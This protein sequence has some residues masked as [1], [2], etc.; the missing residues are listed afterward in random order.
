MYSGS[1]TD[2]ANQDYFNYVIIN[3]IKKHKV[4]LDVKYMYMCDRNCLVGN[5]KVMILL[6]KII[7]KYCP[8]ID[9]R[10]EAIVLRG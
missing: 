3:Y 10:Q 5:R 4:Y 7:L 2:D 8:I 1:Y 9:R 6:Y